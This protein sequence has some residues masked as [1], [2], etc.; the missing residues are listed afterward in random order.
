MNRPFVLV[1]YYSVGGSVKALA[2]HIALGIEASGIDTRVRTVPS[3]STTIEAVSSMIPDDGDLY[4]SDEDLRACSGL[5][6]GSPTRFGNM[7]AALKY[8]LDGSS[9]LWLSGDLIDKPF[10]VFTSSA[11]LHGGQETT[12]M[13]MAI[14]LLHHG[15][16]WAGVPYSVT[17]LSQTQTGGTPYGPSH[18]T[19]TSGNTDL[20]SDEISIARAYGKRL[21]ELAQRMETGS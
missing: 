6:L 18:V 4:C 19:G 1:L 2:E 8:F 14:P 12:L 9:D 17:E 10:G 15:M 16:V 13:T 21:G 3:V 5:A 20:S 11:S 7:A